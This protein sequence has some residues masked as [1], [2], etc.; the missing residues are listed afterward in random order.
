[1]RIKGDHIALGVLVVSLLCAVA[2]FVAC[3]VLQ[4]TIPYDETY[5]G[6]LVSIDLVES[7]SGL[8]ETHW[9]DGRMIIFYRSGWPDSWRMGYTYCANLA[10]YT[11]HT[12]KVHSYTVVE[13]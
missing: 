4:V 10:W 8:V 2:C 9:E 6:K 7:D 5:T 11:G 1:M 13:E 3:A 12:G